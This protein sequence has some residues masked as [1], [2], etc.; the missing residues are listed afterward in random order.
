MQ[1]TPRFSYHL[2]LLPDVSCPET[3]LIPGFACFLGC[4]FYELE[5]GIGL[6]VVLQVLMVLYYTARPGIE[7]QARA[8]GGHNYLSITPSQVAR[9]YHFFLFSKIL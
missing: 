6:G 4:L 1:N 5:M 2:L 9:R 3:D 7:V 8:E